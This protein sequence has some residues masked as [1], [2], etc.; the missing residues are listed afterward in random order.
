[1]KNFVFYETRQYGS[2][3]VGM[4]SDQATEWIVD[5]ALARG[6]PFAVVPCCV[7]PSVFPSRRT[8]AG[9]PVVRTRA[10]LRV[11]RLHN[12]RVSV[13][14]RPSLKPSFA[15]SACV[16]VYVMLRGVLTTRAAMT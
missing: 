14:S 12:Y 11:R 6:K 16:C 9:D 5:F 2:L 3:S 15:D 1:M 13:R 8:P 4:H 7:C 10:T